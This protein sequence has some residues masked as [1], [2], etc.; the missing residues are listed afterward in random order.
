MSRK[1]KVKAAVV[2]ALVALIAGAMLATGSGEPA[3]QALAVV[4]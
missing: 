3:A 1:L 2:A 4:R